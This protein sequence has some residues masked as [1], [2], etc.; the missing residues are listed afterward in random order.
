MSKTTV[1]ISKKTA[2]RRPP[3]AASLIRA[4]RGTQTYVTTGWSRS[5]YRCWALDYS[6]QGW[7]RQRVGCGVE[8]ARHSGV[9]VLYAPH[10]EYQQQQQRGKTAES[11]WIIF[12][13]RGRV[14]ALL[15]RLTNPADWCQIRDPDGVIA[16]RLRR[17]GDEWMQQRPEFELRAHGAFL[18]LLGW[19]AT[20]QRAGADHHIVRLPMSER[21]DLPGR[22]E[23][24]IRAN[25]TT[26]LHIADLARHVGLS[27]SALR[28]AY[29]VLTGE[30]PYHTI[31]RLKLEAAKQLLLQ[32][33]LS[34][35]ETASRLGFSSEFH[36]SRLFKQLEGLAPQEYRRMLLKQ[37][38]E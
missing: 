3:S 18:E 36:F 37:S 13:A 2:R 34:V 7:L 31:Q 19:L 26:R 27:A 30:S 9:A 25:L 28:R 6:N 11:S 32:D 5:Q 24:F 38:S 8:F 16:D 14:A 1:V 12:A 21:R 35:K 33:D 15:R 22:I 29:H 10:C 20:A 4:Y 17:I 23:K